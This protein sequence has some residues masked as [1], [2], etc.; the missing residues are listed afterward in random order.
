MGTEP[1]LISDRGESWSKYK[2]QNML[3]GVYRGD[4]SCPVANTTVVWFVP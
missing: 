3:K 4:D 2:V 1:R